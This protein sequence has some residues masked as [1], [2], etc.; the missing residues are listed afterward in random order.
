VVP[1]ANIYIAVALSSF[2]LGLTRMLRDIVVI[3]S[4]PRE[5]RAKIC[6]LLAAGYSRSLFDGIAFIPRVFRTITVNTYEFMGQV[7]SSSVAVG[8]RRVVKGDTP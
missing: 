4:C 6:K 8:S 5:H 7:G 1:A 3:H 2:G